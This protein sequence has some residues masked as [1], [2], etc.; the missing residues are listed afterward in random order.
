MSSESVVSGAVHPEVL[1]GLG[2]EMVLPVIEAST[3]SSLSVTSGVTR[4]GRATNDEPLYRSPSQ[5]AGHRSTHGHK[6][7]FTLL[8]LPSMF[9]GS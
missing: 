6:G 4:A 1:L 5:S 9:D 8:V 7:A 2:D 3:R